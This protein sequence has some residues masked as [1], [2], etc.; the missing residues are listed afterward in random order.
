MM[1]LEPTAFYESNL[2]E[3]RG[4]KLK[5]ERDVFSSWRIDLKP[6]EISTV[7]FTMR[8]APEIV[9]E[10]QRLAYGKKNRSQEVDSDDVEDETA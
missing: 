10:L 4:G 7:R 9:K 6:W 3:E 8:S 5:I 2:A 1:V